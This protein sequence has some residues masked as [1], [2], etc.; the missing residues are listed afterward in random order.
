MLLSKRPKPKTCSHLVEVISAGRRR[1]YTSFMGNSRM[2]LIFNIFRKAVD[3]RYILHTLILQWKG[4]VLKNTETK[5]ETCFLMT[6]HFFYPSRSFKSRNDLLSILVTNFLLIS[7]KK[8]FPWLSQWNFFPC[9]VLAKSQSPNYLTSFSSAQS[10]DQQCRNV[11]M[12][13]KL[14]WSCFIW[15]SLLLKL[16][17]NAKKKLLQ[18]NFL[19]HC[20]AQ[21]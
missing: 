5:I 14:F 8:I 16:P 7:F 3:T 17:S 4:N 2:I 19:S 11:R 13:Q 1:T 15:I 21:R 12:K 10:E 20:F 9:K 6:L 18:S